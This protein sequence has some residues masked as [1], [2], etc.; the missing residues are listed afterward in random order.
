MKEY[1]EVSNILHFYFL[2]WLT[3]LFKKI[4]ISQHKTMITH[5]PLLYVKIEDRRN[6]LIP[7]RL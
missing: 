5:L 7:I 3:I 2:E 4:R 1:Y 6:S